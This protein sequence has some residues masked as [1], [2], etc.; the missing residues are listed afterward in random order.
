MPELT[1]DQLDG[2]FRK[3]A[4]EFDPPFDPAAWRDMKTRL[5]ANDRTLSGGPLIW[6]N[7]LRWGLPILLVVLLTGGGWYAYRRAYPVVVKSNSPVNV[8]S[9]TTPG[10][11]EKRPLPGTASPE[12]TNDPARTATV[13]S[14][15][16]DAD[17]GK[18]PTNI[19]TSVADPVKTGKSA[20]NTVADAKVRKMSASVT[21]TKRSGPAYG[22]SRTER[23]GSI[24]SLHKSVTATR[25]NVT[26]TTGDRSG[27][28]SARVNKSTRKPRRSTLN[29]IGSSRSTT[30]YDLTSNRL[31]FNERRSSGNQKATVDN[32]VINV[33]DRTPSLTAGETEQIMLP[34][35]SELAIHPAKW[36]KL[37][38]TNREVTA[39]PDTMQRSAK[40]K[41]PSERGLSIRAVVSPDLSTIGL[42]NFSRPGTNLGL[43][44]EYRIASRWS[45]QAGVIQSTKVYRALPS[46]YSAPYG[47]WGGKVVPGSVDG[48]CNMLD[49]PLNVRYDFAVRSRSNEQLPSR[50]FVSGGVTSYIMKKEEYIFNYTSYQHN[51]NTELTTSTGTFGFS[52]LNLSV[53]YERAFSKRLSWQ[54]EP[55]IKMPLK[56]VG[57][58]N[59]NLISTGAFFSIRYKLF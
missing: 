15:E 17:A 7:L 49:I 3:S 9:A 28:T 45:V 51:Q 24:G 56:G 21:A 33:P 25:G 58:F 44:L 35:L 30:N 19:V 14:K 10:R 50:W 20:E 39:H 2:L 34:A 1:D 46:E 41:L 37:A 26:K 42:K 48:I 4:E 27:T 47:T 6:K 16:S 22:S 29:R 11:T 43:L 54:V 23:K 57:Y 53:G 13:G 40:P 12:F 8:K 59:M 36:P 38:F 32:R 18:Q 52:N 31:S 5:D 55:F